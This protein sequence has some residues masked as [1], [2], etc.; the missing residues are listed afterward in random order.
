M[1]ET[2]E[3]SAYGAALLAMVGT[4]QYASVLDVCDTA[5]REASWLSPRAEQSAIYAR[6]HKVYQALYPATKVVQ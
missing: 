3:G 4:R 1:L 2:E 6:G 5:V